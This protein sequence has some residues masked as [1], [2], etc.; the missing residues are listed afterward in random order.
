LKHSEDDS[1]GVS[2]VNAQTREASGK[3]SSAG[4]EYSFCEV[5]GVLGR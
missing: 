4:G 3:G 5:G 2:Y 1:R